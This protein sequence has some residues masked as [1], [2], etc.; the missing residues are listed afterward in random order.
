MEPY[1]AL[2]L[3][4][5]KSI[6]SGVDF[7]EREKTCSRIKMSIFKSWLALTFK[8][9]FNLSKLNFPIYKLVM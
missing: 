4:K 3:K 7:L 1:K 5:K 2:Y 9:Y 6:S 8:F